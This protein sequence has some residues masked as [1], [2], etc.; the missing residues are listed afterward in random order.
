MTD[1]LIFKLAIERTNS[2]KSM[3]K[4]LLDNSANVN[5]NDENGMTVLMKGYKLK[6]LFMKINNLLFSL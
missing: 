2:N 4:Y 5:Q 6:F 1:Y 3:V